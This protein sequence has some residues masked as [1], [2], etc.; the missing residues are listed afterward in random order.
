MKRVIQFSKARYYFFAF[1]L[2]L[3]LSGVAG[4]IFNGGFNLGVDFKAGLSQQFQ[5]A[6]AS[7]SLQYS[8]T[9]KMEV[10]MPTG[11]QALTAPGDF[12]VA[13]TDPVSGARQ[14]F[15]YKFAQYAS[16]QDLLGALSAVP[17]LTVTS[18]GDPTLKSSDIIPPA[19]IMD[20]AGK[21]YVF[22]SKPS[23]GGATPVG[24]GEVRQILSPLGNFDLQ[25][26]GGQSDQRFRVRVESKGTDATFQKTTEDSIKRLLSVKYGEDQILL[27][28]SDF[29]Q[30]RMSQALASQSIWL[31]VIA[32]LFILI[33]MVFR[34]RPAIFAV[35]AVLGICHDALVMLAFDAVFRIEMDAGTIAAILTIL[36]YS[37]NDTIV[38]F[39][40]VREN[41]SIMRGSTMTAIMDTSFTQNLGRTFITSGATLLTVLSLFLFT[42]GTMKTFSLNMLVGL[43][44]G[45]YSTFISTFIALEWLRWSENRKKSRDASKYGMG[46]ER[47]K[48]EEQEAEEDVEGAEEAEAQP[49]ALTATPAAPAVPEAAAPQASAQA[50]T[51]APVQPGQPEAGKI[52]SSPGGQN[53]GYRYLHKRHKRRHH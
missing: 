50:E 1:S 47:D 42:S 41:N 52:S 53:Q 20:Q 43:I 21:R 33:Y 24:I 40:R 34:F 45:T 12:I 46:H 30:P 26:V 27:I 38:I 31:A 39:D 51:Q 10:T 7:F 15:A 2:L 23:A 49:S 32:V 8:G 11:E 3:M 16:I 48:A 19:A 35:A 17:G 28:S 6:P 25:A 37:I 36:G 5:I 18:I 9:D 14:E 29:M 22:N 13:L 4:Y 44:E